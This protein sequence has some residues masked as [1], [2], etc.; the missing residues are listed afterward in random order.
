MLFVC[1][2]YILGVVGR[3]PLELVFK[4]R[5]LALLS[6][7]VRGRHCWVGLKVDAI[8]GNDTDLRGNGAFFASCGSLTAEVFEA[9]SDYFFVVVIACHCSMR[10]T[11]CSVD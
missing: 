8:L 7:K 3:Q 4:D 6:T 2:E 1:K 11:G 5:N 9:H 10:A